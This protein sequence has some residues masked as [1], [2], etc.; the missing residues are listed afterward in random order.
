VTEAMRRHG[1][2]LDVICLGL[3]KKYRI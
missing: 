3:S 1:E 2:N